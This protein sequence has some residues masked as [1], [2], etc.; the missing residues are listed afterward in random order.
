M[1]DS[2]PEDHGY[3]SIAFLDG[4]V[5]PASERQAIEGPR[6]RPEPVRPAAL[7]DPAARVMTDFTWDPPVTVAADRCIDDALQDMV[8]AGVR[9]LLVMRG[10]VVAG[11]ITSY[12]IQSER[13]LQFLSASG[14]TRHA[15]IEAGHIMTPWDR[16]P[17]VEVPWVTSA[18][19]ADVVERLRSV[20]GSH[21]LVV[22]YAEQGGA[23]VR[24]MFS[25]TQLER[26]LGR[27]L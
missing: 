15:E 16:V 6:R 9:A 13:P 19:V 26:Q 24:G 14:F 21:L 8:A 11:L 2:R 10:E 18:R 23:F 12:D 27:Q 22:V 20:R 7:T 5:L 25:R 3:G 17:T 1:F 4:S